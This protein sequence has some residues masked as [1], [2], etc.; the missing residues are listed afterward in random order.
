M[1][2]G[3]FSYGERKTLVIES[4]VDVMRIDMPNVPIEITTVP[5]KQIQIIDPRR[6]HGKNER[7]I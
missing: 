1:I 2:R 7:R 5:K 4:D 3:T 6:H